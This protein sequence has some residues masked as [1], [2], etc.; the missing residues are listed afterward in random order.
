MDNYFKDKNGKIPKSNDHIIDNAR[1]LLAS[2]GYELNTKQEYI[3]SKDED[4][5]GE[6][7][8]SSLKSKINDTD[9]ESW[10]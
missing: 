2:L 5:R 7:L 4:F 10:N 6:S 1:Y 8:E 3:E 9:W